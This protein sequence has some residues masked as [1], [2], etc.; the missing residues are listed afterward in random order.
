MA[1]KKP[2]VPKPLSVQNLLDI[3]EQAELDMSLQDVKDIRATLE[4]QGLLDMRSAGHLSI[5]WS[6]KLAYRDL[7]ERINGVN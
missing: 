5:L 3:T 7:L 1:W 4:T 6:T 2:L